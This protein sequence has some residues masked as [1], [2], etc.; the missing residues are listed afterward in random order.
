LGREVPALLPAPL[1]EKLLHASGIPPG[2]APNEAAL[3]DRADEVA[4]DVRAAF[5]RHIGEIGTS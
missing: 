3:R 2:A 1:L 4:R 5:V